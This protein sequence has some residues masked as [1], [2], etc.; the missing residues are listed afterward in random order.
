MATQNIPVDILSVKQAVS[1]LQPHI[2]TWTGYAFALAQKAGLSPE[3]AARIFMQPVLD[4]KQTA[5]QADEV[6]LEQQA[7]QNATMM[8]LL[9]GADNVHLERDGDTWLLKAALG[10]FK[11]KLEVWDVSLEF[12]AGWLG[13]QARLIGEPKGITYSSWLEGDTLYMQL[14]LKSHTSHCF[15][16]V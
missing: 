15:Q 4:E 14:R 5:F 12:F 16:A 11:Q 13:E 2:T 3:A 6:Q 10:D 9:H 1:W 8:A 7:K